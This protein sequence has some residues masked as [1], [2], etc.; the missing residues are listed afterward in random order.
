VSGSDNVVAASFG[1]A[2]QRGYIIQT[3]IELY[4]DSES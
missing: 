1:G 2:P 3:D 4:Y